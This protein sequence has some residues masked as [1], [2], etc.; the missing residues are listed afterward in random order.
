EMDGFDHATGIVVIASTNRADMLD[1]ALLRPG[2]F[3]RKIAVPLPDVRGRQEILS[4]HATRVALHGEVD[5]GRI[6]RGTPGFSGADLANL[7]NEA[8]ILAAR[9]G[10]S[11]VTVTHIE[12]ARDR[13]MMGMERSGFLFDE[14]ERY[15]TAVHEAGHVA[16]GVAAAHT[17]PVHKVSILPRGRALGV[18]HSLP[19]RD[20]LMIKREYLEDQICMML[21]G[22]AAEIEILGTMTAG[23]ADDIERA[24]TLS[25]RM[26]AELGM[27]E[28]GP[29][30]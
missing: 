22:R 16:V 26:V 10:A 18:T 29:I 14:E 17:D 6:A 19:E 8:A 15:A 5:L 24:A 2:R 11:G 30:C 20:R 23:A 4:V 28:L 13:A 12:R 9:E 21:G 25:R 1:P 3:D 7:L 27:S